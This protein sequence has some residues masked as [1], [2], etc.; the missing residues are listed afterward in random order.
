MWMRYVMM[1]VKL[2]LKIW[3]LLFSCMSARKRNSSLQSSS[4]SSCPLACSS[5]QSTKSV[6]HPRSRHQW[7]LRPLLPPRRSEIHPCTPPTAPLPAQGK[8]IP[9][10]S[11]VVVVVVVVVVVSEV[12]S[13]VVVVVVVVGVV[14][15]VGAACSRSSSISSSISS[16]SVMYW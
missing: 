8:K 5:P 4:S 13:V 14:G 1:L 7:F 16:S 11:I 10:G 12:V 3:S 6:S 15:V 2:K 9:L